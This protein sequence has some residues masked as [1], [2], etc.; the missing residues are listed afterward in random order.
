MIQKTDVRKRIGWRFSIVNPSS[1]KSTQSAPHIYAIFPYP[2]LRRCVRPR[3][4]GPHQVGME[5]VWTR[6]AGDPWISHGRGFLSVPPLNHIPVSS[7]ARFMGKEL[8]GPQWE[9]RLSPHRHGINYA[10]TK[11]S[12][13]FLHYKIKIVKSLWVLSRKVQVIN[14]ESPGVEQ[15][16]TKCVL[17]KQKTLK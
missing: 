11:S 7:K 8:T 9:S 5:D 3:V 6:R 15:H 2:R 14:L 1:A 12:S 17:M 16:L 4:W 10:A 13:W